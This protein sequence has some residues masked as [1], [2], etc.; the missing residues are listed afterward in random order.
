MSTLQKQRTA[1]LDEAGAILDRAKSANRSLTA[2]ERAKVTDQ[3]NEA[4][5]LAERIKSAD[6]DQRLAK[7]IGAVLR[8][9]PDTSGVGRF[10]AKTSSGGLT[11]ALRS[12]AI[13][14]STSVVSPV[15]L[16]EPQPIPIG[17]PV[18][19][20]LTVVPAQVVTDP[21]NVA[22]LRQT[23]RVNN[24]EIVAPGAEKPTS[25]YAFTRITGEL[26]T[27]AHISEPVDR[28]WLEDFSELQAFVSDELLNGLDERVEEAILNGTSATFTGLLN[29]PGTQTQA[30]SVD[31]Y[32][33]LRRSL[34]KLQ[35]QGAAEPV[36]VLNPL[37]WEAM[38]LTRETGSNAFLATDAL[39]H[40]TAA[41]DADGDAIGA[42]SPPFGP[43]LLA[44]WGVPV[45][46]SNAI[47]AGQGVMFDRSAVKLYTDQ[48]VKVEWDP[49]TGFTRNEVL[50]R[51]EGRFAVGV[52]KPLWVVNVDMS[53]A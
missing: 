20:L 3:L 42:A 2:A 19:G 4:Q 13:A 36:A 5:R 27:I 40:I 38:S 53:A 11:S 50:G 15:G 33:T 45:V 1:L 48:N 14:P 39:K 6:D 31:G 34:T 47:A 17:R 25:A 29:T 37:D 32:E 18:R 46:L 44:S 52:L 23:T 21:P 24:A 43:A 35:T 41:G 7:Q 30:W 51:G 8:D 49:S 12:K 22:F 9:V 26:S 28:Y 16:V 10:S